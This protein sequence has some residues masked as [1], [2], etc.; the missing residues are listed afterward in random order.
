MTKVLR[1]PHGAQVE[2]RP[3]S[4]NPLMYCLDTNVIVACLRN[5]PSDP[6]PSLHLHP[7]SQIIVPHQVV[8]ELLLGARKSAQ[9]SRREAE[10]RLFLS[11]FKV[12][13]PNE[14]SL[15]HYVSIRSFLESQGTPIGEADLWI[16]AQAR[17]A[18]AILVTRNTR[19]FVRVPLLQTTDWL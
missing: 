5:R 3:R 10:V 7:S 18:Q 14:E 17:A 19:E 9:P 8:A 1:V 13:W 6:A 16:A 4:E 12:L 11:P 15:E 2:T